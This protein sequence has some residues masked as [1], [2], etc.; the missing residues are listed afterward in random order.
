MLLHGS[1]QAGYCVGRHGLI[2]FYA[3]KH[4]ALI[5]PAVVALGFTVGCVIPF[6]S[7]VK[8]LPRGAIP[9]RIAVASFENR[10]SFRGQWKLGPGIADLLV[11]ELVA[12]KNF[13]V[14]ERGKLDVVVDEI[15]RQKHKLFRKEGR[16]D[17]GRLENARY[18]I[19]G[20]I[21]DFSQTGGGS[22][23][24]GFR[25]LFIGGSGYTARVGLALT[26][27]DIESGKIIDS[28]QCAGKARAGE[29]YGKGAYKSIH[30]GGDKF[31]RTPLG[32]ATAGAIRGGLKGI[33]DKIPKHF[34]QPMIAEVTDQQIILNGGKNRGLAA[35]QFYRVRG[36]GRAV[37]DPV[38]GDILEVLPGPVLGVLR[39]TDIRESVSGAEVIQGYGFARGQYLERIPPPAKIKT[40][41]PE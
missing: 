22:L 12:S 28:V 33:V 26:I 16:V 17:E 5:I 23:W 11:S 9:P 10:S 4:H 7:P 31:F 6:A 36:K 41:L 35:N 34:W 20:V 1:I 14:L 13:V 29:A 2:P 24:M 25:R 39:V 3:M 38:T 15:S 30:F 40:R 32:V 21:T 18:L 27:V 37:T 19:R 8:P